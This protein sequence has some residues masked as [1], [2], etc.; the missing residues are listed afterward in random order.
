MYCDV[1]LSLCSNTHAGQAQVYVQA[2]SGQGQEMSATY[3]MMYIENIYVFQIF[4]LDY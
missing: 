3:L 2:S 1:T 4:I